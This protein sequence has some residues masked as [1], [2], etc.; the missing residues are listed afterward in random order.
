MRYL[1]DQ[2]LK[3]H[4]SFKIGGPADLFCVPRSVEEVKE[5][6]KYA[7]GRRMRLAVLGAGTNVLAL[8]RG[9]RGLVI[10]LGN[11]LN[12]IKVEGNR[13]RVGAGVLIPR[14]IK[15]LVVS[16]LG[17]LEFLAGIPGSVG[18]AVMMNAGA[19]GKDIG[20][21]VEEVV[22]LNGSGREKIIKKKKLG[23]GY[24]RSRLQS[25][26]WIVVEVVLRLRRQKKRT[27]E[28]KMREYL[29][30][31]KETQP[32]GIP[33]SGSIFKN[34]KGDFAGRLIEKAGC[35]GM[36]VGDAQ[37]SAKHGNFIVN[38]GDARAQDVIKLMTA[39]QR[40][41]RVKLEPEIKILVERSFSR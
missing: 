22:V 14:L 23:F 3:K 12:G 20:R 34:P 4:T 39:L 32:L 35:K 1:R 8:D 30:K 2:A 31:R 29:A 18:G 24:R 13:V 28:K 36:R 6:I 16:G 25:K 15:K 41:V 11:G 26:N 38:L 40:A 5:A 37:V 21:Y 33:N 19:W 27:S 17:G 7:K 9:F 10:K